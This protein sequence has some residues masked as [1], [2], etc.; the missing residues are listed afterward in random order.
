MQAFLNIIWE[1]EGARHKNVRT[2]P[3]PIVLYNSYKLKKEGPLASFSHC[4]SGCPRQFTP[5]CHSNSV[6]AFASFSITLKEKKV[7]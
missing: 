3:I 4:G 2:K 6:E 5:N 7:K 1:K